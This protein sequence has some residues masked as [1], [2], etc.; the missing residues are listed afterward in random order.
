M[1]SS[2]SCNYYE[3][4]QLKNITTDTHYKYCALHIN[5]HSVKAKHDQLKEMIST[6]NSKQVPLH[7]ILLCETFLNDQSVALYNIEGY[8]LISK[9]R[10]SGNRGGVAIYVLNSLS[11]LFVMI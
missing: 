4:D 5:I 2:L 7:F 1:K 11:Y 10:K 3:I 8:N 6:L 9:N